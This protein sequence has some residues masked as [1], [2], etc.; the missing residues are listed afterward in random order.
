MLQVDDIDEKIV[1]T[2]FMGWLLSTNF[3]FSLSKSPPN[4]MVE[5]MLQ[6]QKH[7]NA[8]DTMASRRDR[9]VEPRE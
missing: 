7:V 4:N 2:A 8:E 9:V 6:A 5:L 3:S 1:L